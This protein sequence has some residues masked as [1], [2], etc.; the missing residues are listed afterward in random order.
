MTNASLI[1]ANRALLSEF[2]VSIASMIKGELSTRD[3]YMNEM[4][5]KI[6]VNSSTLCALLSRLADYE[7]RIEELESK[8][9]ETGLT[10]AQIR[11]HVMRDVVLLIDGIT[12][13]PTESHEKAVLTFLNEH[14]VHPRGRAFELG[15]ISCAYSLGKPSDKKRTQ[16]VDLSR[17]VTTP[18]AVYPI[19]AA[20]NLLRQ[21]S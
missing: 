11:D 18:L 1:A 16:S 19:I 6:N 14:F 15:E 5:Q 9:G 10:R 17:Y 4:S 12:V 7:A 21:I 8:V 13:K 20:W 2:S 3:R